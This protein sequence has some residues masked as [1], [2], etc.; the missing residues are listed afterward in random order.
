MRPH[1]ALISSSCGLQPERI[2]GHDVEEDS[3]FR[4]S[5][6]PVTTPRSSLLLMNDTS[7][8][9]PEDAVLADNEDPEDVEANV[10]K[11]VLQYFARWRPPP[12]SAPRLAFYRDTLFPELPYQDLALACEVRGK[13]VKNQ[14]K[15]ALMQRL[16]TDMQLEK[17]VLGEYLRRLHRRVLLL[18]S[19]GS[20]QYSHQS[21]RVVH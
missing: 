5:F 10:Y 11:E 19:P 8:P 15:V 6:K 1:C 21:G 17:R 16:S 20:L 13:D 3:V 12:P 2:L 14:N 18:P 7:S 4:D 9:P